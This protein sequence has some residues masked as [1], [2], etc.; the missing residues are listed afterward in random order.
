M[1]KDYNMNQLVLPLDLE[2]KLQ[3]NDIAFSIHHLV[4]SIPHEAFTSFLRHAGCPAYH[5]RM[6]L[7]II[8]CGYTQSAF[9]GRKIEDLSK[10]SMRMMWLAQGYEPSYRTI[11]RFRVHPEVKELIRQCFVQFRCQLVE[12][13]LID[14]EA[15]FIDGTKIEANAN[16][17]TFVWKKSVEKHHRN[18]LEKSNQLYNDLLENQIIPEIQRENDE[19]LSN[20]ELAQV[21]EKL[22]EIIEELTEQIASSDDVLERKKLRSERKTPKQI[23][24]QVQE[25]IIRK[26]KYEKDFEIFDTRNSYSKS[27]HDATFMRMKDDYM[28][29]GQLKAGYN[30]QIAT[31]GQ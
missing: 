19:Q 28:K 14:Q 21:A 20:E 12:E 30:L 31:E 11:N 5:P 13:K 1:F 29:N 4:E 8:L 22:D 17:F 27:D 18:L 25:W 2:V 26:Q 16:K 6:M 24:K 10:D 3:E 23:V 15:I 7:K 9:S